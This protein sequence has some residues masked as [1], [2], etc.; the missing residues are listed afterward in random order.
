[1]TYLITN[2]EANK[3]YTIT[4]ANN[5][6]EALDTFNRFYAWATES[7]NMIFSDKILIFCYNWDAVKEDGIYKIDY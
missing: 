2:E 5:I 6:Q 3:V 4:T 1:M 7:E